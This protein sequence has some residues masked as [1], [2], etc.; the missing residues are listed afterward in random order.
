MPPYNGFQRG[1]PTMKAIQIILGISALPA[2]ADIFSDM[3]P[4]EWREIPNSQVGT[5]R[6]DCYDF[7]G[8]KWENKA[9]A[10]VSGTGSMVA[11]DPA[12]GQL[13]MQGAGNADY[14]T[15]WNPATNKWTKHAISDQGWMEYSYTGAIGNG[16]FIAIGG[17][18]VF[19]WD[20]AKPDSPPVKLTTKGETGIL[21]KSCPGF[22]YDPV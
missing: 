15:Q 10:L 22:V 6:V 21:G 7:D 18:L 20:L 5:N 2:L 11:Y 13:W 9:D 14:F 19:Q 3:K 1:V 17:G 16:K 12:S 4:G 8:K